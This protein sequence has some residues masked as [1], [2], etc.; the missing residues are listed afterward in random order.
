[1]TEDKAYYFFSNSKIVCSFNAD[2][3]DG[4]NLLRPREN[5]AWLS[6]HCSLYVMRQH[7]IDCIVYCEISTGLPQL[8][9]IKKSKG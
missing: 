6:F 1:M 3:S 7:D 8:W 5:R 9:E 2:T 4:Q